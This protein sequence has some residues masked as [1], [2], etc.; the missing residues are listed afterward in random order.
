MGNCFSNTNQQSG[1]KKSVK[2]DMVTESKNLIVDYVQENNSN[3]TSHY[4]I[5]AEI[6]GRGAYGEVR[7]AL[8][9]PTNEMR[10]I[11]I[12]YKHV[13]SSNDQE[14]IFREVNILKQLDH[15]NIIK[16]YEYFSDTKFIFIVMELVEGGELF[17]KIMNVHHFSE[18]KAA[19]IFIQLLRAVNYLHSNKI[20]HRDLKP[21]NIL[22][23]GENVKVIDFG[24]S[25]EFDSFKKMKKTYGT[26]YYIAPE[27]I[28][29]SYDE[30]CDVWSCGVILYIMLS[31]SPPFN[32]INDDNVIKA[33]QKGHF[34]FDMIEFEQVSDSAK[35]LIQKML[36]SNPNQ[37][38]SIS[39]A[40]N[41]EWFN[42][43]ISKKEILLDP[44]VLSNLKKFNVRTKMQEAIFFFIINNMIGRD[45]KKE[46]MET[47]RSLDTNQDGVLSKMELING[48]KK[49]KQFIDEEE[50]DSLMDRMDGNKDRKINYTEFVG[51]AIDKKKLLS[52]ERMNDCFRIFDKDK[53]GK[54]SIAELK[55]MFQGKNIVDE[56]VWIK[57][58]SDVDKN[59]DGEIELNEFK[60][61]LLK[62]I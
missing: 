15:P 14:C 49:V 53:S 60:E 44:N 31:G 13:C 21:E 46:L 56:A 11:K 18:H 1:D 22:F 28:E 54:I 19:K 55:E 12:I 36:T 39:E 33:V 51:A 47:F 50:V 41:D 25:R 35:N 7:K 8:H 6:I 29:H 23:E 61:I 52:D 43:V 37:R 9:I 17:D 32:G 45:E 5:W 30:K 24:T 3:I 48:L 40:I 62:L 59:G 42:T 58:V 10:A 34:S 2:K 27:V 4:K 20:F 57:M 38:I 26:P 16:I